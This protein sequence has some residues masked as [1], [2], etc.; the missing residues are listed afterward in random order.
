MQVAPTVP[1]AGQCPSCRCLLERDCSNQTAL[2]PP[3]SSLAFE[4]AA[5]PC[6]RKMARQ[7]ATHVA[8]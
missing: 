4:A 3:G 6:G 8:L 2:A 5:W 7:G 1:A